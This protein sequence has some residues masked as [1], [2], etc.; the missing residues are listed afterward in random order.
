MHYEFE[1]PI[2]DPQAVLR[3]SMDWSE[4]LEEGESITGLPEVI[5]S[6]PGQLVADQ[7]AVAAGVVSWRIGGGNAGTDYTLTVRVVTSLG[8]TDDRSIIYK[9]RER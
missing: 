3:H 9:V 8:R 2:K 4:W 5:S 6:V 1:A 7:V